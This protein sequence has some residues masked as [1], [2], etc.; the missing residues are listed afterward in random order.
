MHQPMTQHSQLDEPL[1][2]S[3]TDLAALLKATADPLRLEILHVLAQ[4]SYGVSELSGI[5]GVLQSGMSHH[6]KLLTTA[7]FTNTRR[8]GNT[9]YYKRAILAS[10]HS[11]GELQ[12]TLFKSVDAL[13]LHADITE[14]CQAISKKRAAD[15]QQFFANNAD[16][17]RKQQD[18]IASH[19]V[20][21]EQVAQL[22][23]STTLKKNH[24][25]LEVGPGQGEFLPV[26]SKQFDRVIALDNAPKMLEYS[27][28]VAADKGLS[29]VEF[30]LGSTERLAS[31]NIAADCIVMNMVLHHTPAPA[32]IFKHLSAALT[33]GGALLV[34]DLCRHEQEWVKKSCGDL[35]Q[36]FEPVDFTLWAQDAGLDAGQSLY[37][38]LRNGFQI[39][40]RQFI[41]PV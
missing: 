23:G 34:T 7:G 8:E 9:I 29:N 19:S 27:K 28:A 20:Y 17:F 35:W 2:Q 10:N 13:T 21:A 6:L 16:K 15:S 41:K 39:Q 36:G 32:E 3:S 14:R 22:L 1:T 11:H 30:I 37:I 12:K 31:H 5:F 18:L 4:N 25:A 26:L 38:A 33:P 24:L 40:C